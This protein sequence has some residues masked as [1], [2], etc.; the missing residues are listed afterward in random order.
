MGFISDSLPFLIIEHHEYGIYSTLLVAGHETTSTTISWILLE[1]ARNPNGQSRL[2]DEIRKT[3][4]TVY[5][6]GDSQLKVQ[7]LDAMPYLN[8]VIKVLLS[9]WHAPSRFTLSL[10]RKDYGS[11]QQYLNH[12]EWPF[13]MKSFRYLSQFSRNPEI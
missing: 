11:T 2:R 7:D 4:A 6:R 5:A 10:R 8:A 13:K 3:E 1:L 12:F 9:P